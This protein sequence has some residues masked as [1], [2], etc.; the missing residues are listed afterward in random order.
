M[1]LTTDDPISKHARLQDCTGLKMIKPTK[2]VELYFWSM[3]QN[4]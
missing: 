1:A 2:D 4:I 3:R